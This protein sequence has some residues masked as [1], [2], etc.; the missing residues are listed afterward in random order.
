MAQGGPTHRRGTSERA[1]ERDAC[2]TA[3]LPSL[4]LSGPTLP[5]S[6]FPVSPLFTEFFMDL[7]AVSGF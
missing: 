6:H 5:I 7:H 3:R 4:P 2:K 1:R